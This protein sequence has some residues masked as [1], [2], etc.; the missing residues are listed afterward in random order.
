MVRTR[1][2]SERIR[3]EVPRQSPG[4]WPCH[5]TTRDVVG[6]RGALWQRAKQQQ[7]TAHKLQTNHSRGGS[8]AVIEHSQVR[9]SETGSDLS[10]LKKQRATPR[11]S[12]LQAST[13][14]NMSRHMAPFETTF[15]WYDLRK[16]YLRGPRCAASPANPT[17][18]PA[19]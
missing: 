19:K 14:L 1:L 6:S 4:K 16:P 15:Q 13:S 17:R 3:Q 7:D 9:K 12:R 5:L 8:Y 10:V 2:R 18:S 11:R